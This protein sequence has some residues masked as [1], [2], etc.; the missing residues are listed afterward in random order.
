[1][2]GLGGT[3]K[4]LLQILSDGTPKTSKQL[5]KIT[6]FSDKSVEGGLY[7]LWKTGLILRTEKPTMEPSRTFKGRA[8][9]RS[10]LRKYHFYILGPAGKDALQFQGLRFV[11]A[12]GEESKKG[13]SKAELVLNFLRENGERAFFSKDIAESLKDKGVKPY[14]VMTTVRRYEKKGQI[15]VRGYRA[16]DRQTPFKEG[17]LLTW[18]D[19]DKAREHAIEEAVQRTNKALS[20]RASTS[21][22]IERIHF[23][24]DQ[25]IQSTKLRDL[26][27]FE[28]IHNKLGCSE[29]EAEG[30]VARALQLYPDLKEIK[31]F[32]AYRYYYHASMTEEDLQAA[33]EMKQN[34]VR[35]LKGRANR[36]GH[37]WEGCVEWFVDKFTT[38]A[39]F[40]TQSH[41]GNSMD[42]RR[43]TLHLLRSVGGRRQNAEVDRVWEVTP[44]V[45]A[46][47]IIYILECK[48]GLVRK[49]NV[50]DFLEVMRWSKEFG[51]DTPDG[52][53]VK[54]GVV[55][56]FAGSAFNPKESV[57]LKDE[58]EISLATYAARMNIQLLKASDFNEKL[59]ERGVGEKETV[60]RIC[61]VS[62]DEKQV[63]EILEQIWKEP[64]KA[65]DV[66]ANVSRENSRLFEFEKML[67]H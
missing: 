58:T 23:I 38:G 32:D 11:K 30:A 34:Y 22:I 59:R 28:F 42:P 41:R 46:Q 33:K 35:V 66:L 7:R 26:L 63:R 6:G 36:I 44:G 3:Q 39:H 60:Q 24:R 47:P 49:E 55:G 65:E 4:R 51:V 12:V 67:E 50:D 18:I 64:G 62:K 1:M 45:F 14:D 61:R 25:V 53:Q 29:H 48:W 56:V 31:L 20:Q 21:P 54:Q 10:H 52:R 15:Y 17:Y 43:I 13:S 19:Y 37:N 2:V 57:R 9:I 5:V 8:G 16:F 27:S 40:W